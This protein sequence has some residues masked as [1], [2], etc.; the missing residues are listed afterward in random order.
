M[1]AA[2]L[3][4]DEDGLEEWCVG[5]YACTCYLD[6][7]P[8]RTDVLSIVAKNEREAHEGRDDD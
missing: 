4:V 5:D 1:R 2:E 6:A 3:H 8:H 7:G